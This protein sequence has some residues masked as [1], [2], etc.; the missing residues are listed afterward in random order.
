MDKE[1]YNVGFL[2]SGPRVFRARDIGMDIGR[3]PDTIRA[4]NNFWDLER[5]DED[6]AKYRE[7]GSN[8]AMLVSPD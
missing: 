5:V 8:R 1:V 6:A 3:W 4:D 7:R 2:P